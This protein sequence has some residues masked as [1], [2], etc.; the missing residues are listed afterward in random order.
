MEQIEKSRSSIRKVSEFPSLR[1]SSIH[2]S[3]LNKSAIGYSG[4]SDVKVD[5]N[6]QIDTIPIAIAVL[7]SLFASKQLTHEEFE[8]A[9]NKLLETTDKYKQLSADGSSNV[10]LFHPNVWGR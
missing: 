1:S 4:N 7:C 5:V 9:F 2:D 3:Q 10:K 8:I 6:V